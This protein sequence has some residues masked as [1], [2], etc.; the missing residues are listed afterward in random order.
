MAIVSISSGSFSRGAEVAGKLATEL[1]Y[2]C[3]GRDALLEAAEEYDVP[4]IKLAHAIDDPLSVFDRITGGR[5]RYIAYIKAALFRHFRADNVIYHGVADE[6]FPTGVSHALRVRVLAELDDRVQIVIAR[7]GISE[8]EARRLVAKRD[9]ARRRWALQLYGLAP[10]DPS[11]YDAVV[12]VG[13]MGT[14]GAADMLCS[15]ARQEAFQTT[16]ASQAAMDDLALVAAVAAQIADTDVEPDDV[17]VTAR[18]GHVLIKIKTSPGIIAGTSQSVRS[19]YV[20]ELRDKLYRRASQL[21][22]AKVTV[23]LIHR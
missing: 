10:E 15:L 3:L 23:T 14:D 20:K 13:K 4:E 19:Y 6:L 8:A 5:R 12:H 1:G 22:G 11:L 21:P 7:E 16:A 9:K 2:A 17:A 18:H